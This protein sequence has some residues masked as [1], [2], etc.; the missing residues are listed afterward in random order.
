M[1]FCEKKNIFLSFK[2]HFEIN[3]YQQFHFSSCCE[4]FFFILKF[5]I[6][7]LKSLKAAFKNL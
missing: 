3:A 2:K 4:S 5:K 1:P 7:N 6:W